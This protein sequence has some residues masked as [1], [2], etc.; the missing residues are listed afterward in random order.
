[1]A[2][3]YGNRNFRRVWSLSDECGNTTTQTQVVEIRD[4]LAPVFVVPNDAILYLDLA[5]TVDSPIAS[6]GDVIGETNSCV[7]VGATYVDD[8]SGLTGCN[9]TGTF[10]GVWGFSEIFATPTP[11]NKVL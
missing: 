8:I 6:I 10:G 5:C 4:T 3:L 1:M 2:G 9:G 7:S 11:K